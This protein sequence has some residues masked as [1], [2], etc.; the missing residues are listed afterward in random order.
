MLVTVGPY[1]VSMI[2]VS[3]QRL[4]HVLPTP[5]VDTRAWW[6]WRVP[7]LVILIGV[8]AALVAVFGRIETRGW[9]RPSEPPGWLSARV[10]GVLTASTPRVALTVG[11]FVTVVLGLLSDN[12]APTAG[13]Y[14]VGMPV[15]GLAAFLVGAT[16][17]R[18]ARGTWGMS[19]GMSGP[20]RGDEDP[21]PTP[22][23][24]GQ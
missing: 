10:V 11:G 20:R 7:W 14:L 8:L 4:Q 12:V 18:V 15:G 24:A 9:R 23:R 5:A 19:I 2:D 13:H 22:V 17:L 1:S 6:L 21:A 16:V 3:G